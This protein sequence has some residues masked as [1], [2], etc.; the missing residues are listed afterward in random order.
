MTKLE[1]PHGG[2]PGQT[3]EHPSEPPEDPAVVKPPPEGGG[4]GWFPPYG[5]GYFPGPGEATP[6]G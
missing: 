4:W 3:G 1:H 5:W 6:K 2:P